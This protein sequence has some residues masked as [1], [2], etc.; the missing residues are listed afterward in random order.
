VLDH[1]IRV[2]IIRQLAGSKPPL[3]PPLLHFPALSCCVP[4]H[5]D[6]PSLYGNPW[7][8][9]ELL[10]NTMQHESRLVWR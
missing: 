5:V 3:I 7:K 9:R 10:C 4:C 1:A 6:L 8:S 2:A